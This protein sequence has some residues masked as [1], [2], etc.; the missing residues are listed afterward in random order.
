MGLIYLGKCSDDSDFIFDRL[1]ISIAGIED[2]HKILD[3]FHFLGR[4]DY[5]Q[6]S[7]LPIDI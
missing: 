2:S 4:S 6:E 5:L 3:K 7:Y 1:F